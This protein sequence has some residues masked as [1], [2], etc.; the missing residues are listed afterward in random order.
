MPKFLPRPNVSR[1]GHLDIQVRN[2]EELKPSTIKAGIYEITN[3]NGILSATRHGEAWDRDLKGDNLVLALVHRIEE[4][5]NEK[6]HGLFIL[7]ESI[8]TLAKDIESFSGSECLHNL[9]E[10]FKL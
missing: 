3:D 1:G 7:Q 2:V 10:V 9:R 4:L 5:E 8:A 6:R